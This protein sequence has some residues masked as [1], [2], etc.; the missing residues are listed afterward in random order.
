MEMLNKFRDVYDTKYDVQVEGLPETISGILSGISQLP[1]DEQ[2][3]VQGQ[4]ELAKALQKLFVT[5][6][7]TQAN[8]TALRVV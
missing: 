1:Q 4:V 5:G 6:P 2:E 7:P 3:A 8:C